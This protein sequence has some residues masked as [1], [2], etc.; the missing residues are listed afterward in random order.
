ML[1][2]KGNGLSVGWRDKGDEW[3]RGR[4]MGDGVESEGG[5]R[6]VDVFG[7]QHRG[8]DG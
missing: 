6:E 7:G 3:R 5:R 4:V 2:G 8:G 1:C